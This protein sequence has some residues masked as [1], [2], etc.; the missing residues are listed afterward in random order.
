MTSHI[1]YKSEALHLI[2]Y[3]YFIILIGKYVYRVSHATSMGVDFHPL[4]SMFTLQ[5]RRAWSPA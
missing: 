2:S 5:I 1:I 4:T 3:F